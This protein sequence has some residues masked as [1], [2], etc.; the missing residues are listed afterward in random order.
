MT[1]KKSSH[2]PKELLQ[3][4][5]EELDLFTQTAASR[6]EVGEDGRLVASKESPLEKVVGLARC[7]IGPLFS[8]QRRREQAKKIE[9]LKQAVLN[10]RDIVQSHSALIVKFQEGD[11]T[12]RK[13]AFYALAAIQR[14]NAVIS[15]SDPGASASYEVYNYERKHLLSDEEIKRQPIELPHALSIKF[16]SHADAHPAHKMF[17][18]ISQTFPNVEAKKA[19]VSICPTHKKKL[20]FMID[21]F[22]MKAIRMMQ[23]HLSQSNAMADIVP[24]VKGTPLEI[25]E[26]SN[27]E[28]IAMQQLLEVG[29]GFFVRMSGCFKRHATDPKFL[30]MPM[31][32][33]FRLSFQMTHTGFPYPSQHAGWSLSDSWVEAYPLRPDQV[34]LFQKVNQRKK[35]LAQ[36]LLYDQSV[37]QKARHL[38]KLK[39]AIFDQHRALFLPLFRR[40]QEVC[41]PCV[42]QSRNEIFEAFFKELE[43]AASPFDLLVQAEQQMQDLFI[44]NPIQAL[45]EEWLSA[46]STALRSGTPQEKFHAACERFDFYYRNVLEQFKPATPCLAYVLQRGTLLARSFQSIGLQYLSEKIGFSPPLLNSFERRLQQCAFQQLITFLEEC[47]SQLQITDSEQIKQHLLHAWSNDLEILKGSSA[48]HSLS[49]AIVDELDCYFNSRFYVSPPRPIAKAI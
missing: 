34:P 4:A 38:A 11:E 42:S 44:K 30:T 16:D 17:Q 28:L 13:L 26:E 32:D 23:T 25:D 3:T 2:D 14:Y 35:Q 47:E 5:I 43:Q 33:S 7:L 22:H 20:Q 46:E 45:E 49:L 40:I 21:T 41:S 18:A 48:G 27:P 24:I 29:P 19:S 12:Q 1:K 8:G 39:R 6:L 10:A 31:L 36:Q 9:E 37:I 15:R